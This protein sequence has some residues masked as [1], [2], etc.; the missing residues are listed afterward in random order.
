MCALKTPHRPP[1]LVLTRQNLPT[2]DR[3]LYASAE[4]LSKGAYVLADLGK[5][6]PQLILMASGS[7]VNLIAEVGNRMAEKGSAVRLISFPSWELFIEQEESY[8][9]SVLPPGIELRLAVEAGVS[10][11]WPRWVG[12]HGP[13]HGVD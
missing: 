13:I 5:G 4:G 3:T 12:P 7:E 11:G 10:Q 9:D 1:A 8:R 2:L 6:T